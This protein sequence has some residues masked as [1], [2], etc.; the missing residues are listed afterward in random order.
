MV[1][2]SLSNKIPKVNTILINCEYVI[3][4]YLPCN[5]CIT[6]KGREYIIE[7]CSQQYI[8]FYSREDSDVSIQI[9]ADNTTFFSNPKKLFQKQFRFILV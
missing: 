6:V 2:L 4:N 8:D 1:I 7:K 9:S 5:I 3:I